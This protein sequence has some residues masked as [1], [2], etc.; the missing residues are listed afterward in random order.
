MPAFSKSMSPSD[1]GNCQAESGKSRFLAIV[2]F[3]PLSDE[4][5]SLLLKRWSDKMESAWILE[6]PAGG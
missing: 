5:E 1:M 6:S 3:L 4:C 2:C